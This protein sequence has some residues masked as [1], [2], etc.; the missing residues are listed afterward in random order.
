MFNQVLAF[1]VPMANAAT[2]V[3]SA[4]TAANETSSGLEEFVSTL[5]NRAPYWIA[6]TI[7][8]I[9]S[10][11][12]AKIG[13]KIVSDKVENKLDDDHQGVVGLAG[14]TTFVGILTLGLMIGMRIA[15][16]DL[17]PIVAALGLGM[18][19]AMQGIITNFMAGVLVLL[20]RHFTIGD[21]IEID[22]LIGKIVEIQ[23]RATVLQ[24]LD[25][26]RV[27]VPNADLF[28]KRVI[29]YTSNPFRRLEIIVGVEYSTPLHQAIK[30]CMA[31][32][33]Q[34]AGVVKSPHPN[35]LVDAFSDSSINLKL[36]F[37]VDS[38]SD[39]S[40]T[41][42]EVARILKTNFDKAGINIPFPIR[43]VYTPDPIA[44]D[45]ARA[46]LMEANIGE[47]EQVL[48][49]DKKVAPTVKPSG[50]ERSGSEFLASN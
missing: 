1:F 39:W 10:L 35:V 19:F 6:G 47:F 36:W 8:I 4:Y 41:R 14:R 27:I 28:S 18:G 29:S 9:F 17:T 30:V 15:G 37:W 48:A 21:Y 3:G 5:V 26:T 46:K 45:A 7:I 23:S 43:T 2:A 34:T 25:G 20:A 16:L 49:S 11:V 38:N 33:L 12:I 22:G 24:A 50:S 40:T 31:T 13:K 42:S 44:D 32:M